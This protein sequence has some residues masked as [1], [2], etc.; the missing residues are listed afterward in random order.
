MAFADR[1]RRGT[2]IAPLRT[3]LIAANRMVKPNIE[4]CGNDAP[5]GAE[6]DSSAL[7]DAT[8]TATTGAWPSPTSTAAAGSGSKKAIMAPFGGPLKTGVLQGKSPQGPG[9]VPFGDSNGLVCL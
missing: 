6:M 8:S 3:L 1:L 5:L 9:S 2:R 7:A 4:G